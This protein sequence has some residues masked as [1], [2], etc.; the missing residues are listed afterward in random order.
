[1]IAALTAVWGLL[2]GITG[3]RAAIT[4]AG[5]LMLGIPLPLPRRG[6]APQHER[7]LARSLT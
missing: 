1:M 5:V 6:Y 7:E 2:A 3:P 4:I